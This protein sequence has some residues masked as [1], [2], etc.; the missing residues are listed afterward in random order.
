MYQEIKDNNKLLIKLFIGTILVFLPVIIGIGILF[1]TN[2][3]FLNKSLFIFIY[4]LIIIIYIIIIL[5]LII[6]LFSKFKNK[7]NFYI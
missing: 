6:V 5:T 7:I 2:N 4:N 3:L 1:I